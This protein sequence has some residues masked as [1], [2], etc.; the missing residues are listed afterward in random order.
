[1]G[2]ALVPGL[3]VALGFGIA[4]GYL[5]FPGLI[6]LAGATAALLLAAWRRSVVALWAAAFAVGLALPVR[7]TLPGHLSFQLPNLAEVTGRVVGIP[8]PRARNVSSPLALDN[9]PVNLLVYVPHEPNAGPGD[10]VRLVG[11]WGPP[12]PEPWRES[13]ARRGIHGLFWAREIEVLSPG[14][15]GVMRWASQARQRILGHLY[16][17]LPAGVAN[18]LGALLL[19]T[20][21][22]LP[23]EEEEAFRTAGVAHIFA[24]SGLQVGILVAGMW[25]LL[26]LVRVP[27]PWRY[28]VLIPTV[29]LY[30]LLGGA[31]VSLIRAAIMFAILGLFWVLWERGW[32]LRK[33][34]DPVQGLA[35]AA[36]VVLV[37]W[38]WSALDA[39]FQLS[40]LATAGIVLF[41]P[42]WLGSAARGRLP[43]WLRRVADGLALTA[44]A[45]LGAT[46]VLG[47]VFGDV[48]PYALL[49]NLIL[50]PWSGVILWGGI[51]LTAAGSLPL[52]L[53]V[54]FVGEQLL[55]GPYLAVV[56]WFASLPGASLPV[57]PGF[58]T[59]CL[60]AALG[61]LLVQAVL[62]ETGRP[63]GSAP[64]GLRPCEEDRVPAKGQPSATEP[65]ENAGKSSC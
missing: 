18:H 24:L 34:L 32:V 14:E 12:Q 26:G 27:R 7:E 8:D 33:W 55:I 35:L 40:F 20:Q 63:W 28:L 11:Q 19:G 30:V 1:M 3:G 56:R 42:G 39:G 59:W 10:R 23:D 36:I 13:L 47:T 9:L 53:P 57:G 17:V 49:A 6:A 21:G 2:R 38:P 4:F 41:F 31:E 51:V 65:A 58:G 64:L 25:W 16:R 37:V 54:G 62:E 50:V 60:F 43:A 46:P 61:V 22:M 52:S 45:Q 29:G 15:P 5:F 44:C 48:A